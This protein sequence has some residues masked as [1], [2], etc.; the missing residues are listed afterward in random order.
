MSIKLMFSKVYMLLI[1]AFV[2]VMICFG[3]VI[4][5][6]TASTMKKQ[7]GIKCAGIAGAVAVLVEED[8][9]SFMEF[10]K[11]LDTNSEYYKAIRGKLQRIRLD[12]EDNIAFLYVEKRI[13][14]DTIM[15]VLDAED[16]RAPLYSAPGTRDAITSA[17]RE[18]YGLQAV[19]IPDD[20][21]TNNYGTLLTCYAP[22]LN[23]ETGE[24]L[25]LVGVD[26]SIDQYN[27]IMS[28]Q[29]LTLVL[30]IVLLVML[31][32]LTMVLSSVRLEE[33]VS[34]D[35]LT[36]AYNKAHFMRGL[37]QQLKMSKKRGLPLVVLM[38]DLDHFKKVNDTY[39]HVFGDVVLRTVA[40]TIGSSLR[41]VDCLA[42]YGGEEFAA[43][44]PDTDLELA[45]RAA[46]RIR[47]AVEVTEI[48]NSET[49]E[50]V[51]VTISIGVARMSPSHAASELLEHADK[52]LYMAKC[53]RNAVAAFKER[54]VPAD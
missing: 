44:F 50:Y 36:G 48:F 29:R 24:L 26:V 52:A 54:V 9:T 22:V 25:A 51:K 53:T 49:N 17:E 37:R 43:Y 11:S 10:S 41:K 18:A 28:N 38:A 32:I 19:Y 5:K 12:N 27:A 42:R 16:E 30:S 20:F 6:N 7:L 40:S 46:E 45:E 14:E 8:Y 15:Y 47:G 1:L 39:G 2:G 31:L 33:L 3:L 35:S 34:R 21:V 4:Y 23:P 13:A